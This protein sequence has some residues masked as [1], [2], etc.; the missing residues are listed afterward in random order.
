MNATHAAADAGVGVPAASVS[1]SSRR[2]QVSRLIVRPICTINLLPAHHDPEY[3]NDYLYAVARRSRRPGQGLDQQNH[4]FKC[5]SACVTLASIQ[6]RSI[7]ARVDPEQ[8]AFTTRF[9]SI[10]LFSSHL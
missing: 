5:A 6:V 2:C 1:C 3:C 8:A 10:S 7:Q 4:H 9:Y